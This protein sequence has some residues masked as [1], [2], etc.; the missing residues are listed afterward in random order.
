MKDTLR[1]RP[2][3]NRD[4]TAARKARTAASQSRLSPL[5]R[6]ALVVCLIAPIYPRLLVSQTGSEPSLKPARP[7]Q[8]TFSILGVELDM[9]IEQARSRL[10]AISDPARP[11][12]EEQEDEGYGVERKVLWRMKGTDFAAVLI[13]ANEDGRIKSILGVVRPGKEVPFNLVGDRARAFAQTERAITWEV[14]RPPRRAFFVMAEGS[15]G[16]ARAISLFRPR[17]ASGEGS[18]E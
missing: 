7:G 8:V 2:R 13:K 4:K 5:W 18:Q 12:K 6:I 14:K 10:D 3:M 11:P 1:E 16:R 9:T 17:T 15:N